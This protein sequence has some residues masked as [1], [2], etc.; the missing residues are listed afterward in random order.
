M[1]RIALAL[2]QIEAKGKL[3]G[4]EILQLVNAGLP[5]VQI[6]AEAFGKT[7]AEVTAMV[8][9]GLVPANQAIE[10][11]TE[12]IENNFA[13]AAERQATTWAGLMGT[14]EDL[15]NMGLRGAQ[16]LAS[17]RKTSSIKSLM[18]LQC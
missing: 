2:G 15:K 10:A 1:S 9:D 16:Y 8:S 18:P 11:I 14:F 5:V 3:S 6:L 12:Y 17:S 4:Q 7:T 13:G